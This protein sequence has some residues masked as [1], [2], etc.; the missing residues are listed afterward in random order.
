MREFSNS[1]MIGK[2]RSSSNDTS[3]GATTNFTNS[4]S[5]KMLSGSPS[6]SHAIA[7]SSSQ[8][9]IIRT[10]VCWSRP[11]YLHPLSSRSPT[12]AG[13]YSIGVRLRSTAYLFSHSSTIRTPTAR[14][15]VVYRPKDPSSLLRQ[16]STRMVRHAGWQ[17][18]TLRTTS[19]L[20]YETGDSA[21][22][23]FLSD[24]RQ[25]PLKRPPVHPQYSR[26]L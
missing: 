9:G 19:M 17:S 8:Y 23:P 14:T 2:S 12:V 5:S 24:L 11:L 13:R 25:L 4:V 7:G 15:G 6:P 22:L 3:H 10:P 16:T 26:R 20:L 1:L 21:M 18:D